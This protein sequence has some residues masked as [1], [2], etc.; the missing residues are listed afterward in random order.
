MEY[1]MAMDILRA[2]PAISQ[3]AEWSALL[4]SSRTIDDL[5]SIVRCYV[6]AWSPEDLARLPEDCRPV[7]MQY[8]DD[9]AFHAFRLVRAQ[10][11]GGDS[12]HALN[13]MAAFFAVASQRLSFLMAHAKA[14]PNEERALR[15]NRSRVSS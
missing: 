3:T 6:D 1:E 10:C 11:A 4:H 9:V 15:S 5:L 8:G 7:H 2:A 13:Q 12:N 14:F